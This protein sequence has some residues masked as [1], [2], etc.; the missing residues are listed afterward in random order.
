MASTLNEYITS[1]QSFINHRINTL[2]YYVSSREYQAD[3]I[4]LIIKAIIELPSDIQTKENSFPKD[5][6]EAIRDLSELFHMWEIQKE[7]DI[8]GYIYQGL[9]TKIKKNEKGQ[10]FTPSRIVNHLI[11]QS[12]RYI[13]F[14]QNDI[15]A[16][17]DPACGSGQFLIHCYSTIISA[18]NGHTDSENAPQRVIAQLVGFDSDPIA[19]IIARENLHKIS[20]VERDK[21][22]IHNIDFLK[23]PDLFNQ[24]ITETVKKRFDIILGNPPW[25]SRISKEEK[26]YF[27]YHYQSAATGINTFSLFIE[28]SHDFLRPGGHIS[29][30]IPEAYLNIKSHR[31]SRSL[32]LNQCKIKEIALWGEQFV[33]VFAPC[34]SICLESCNDPQSRQKN[35]INIQNKRGIE[36]NTTL[37]IPQASYHTTPENIF[38]INYS[39]KA[40]N[41]LSHI[42]DSPNCF[43]LKDR[44]KFFL[45]VVTGDNNRFISNCRTSIYN[46]P[47]IVGKDLNQYCI[48]FSGHYIHFNP[49]QLQQVAP[50]HLYNTKGKIL[51]RFI[52]KH[53][54]FAIDYHGYYS[55]NNVNGFIPHDISLSKESLISLLN[56]WALQ[57]YYRNSYF[58]VKVLRG[59]LERLPVKHLTQVDQQKI[60]KL[61]MDIINQ[62]SSSLCSR[63]TIEDIVFHAYNINDRQAYAIQQF[64]HTQPSPQSE[65]LPA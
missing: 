21:I 55:L 54:T 9:Q 48:N 65:L 27:R 39:R 43:Y 37:L 59:N 25:G 33:K 42:E 63:E 58:T 28:R 46:D 12:L 64:I 51:Y 52:S 38:N 47:I 19:C 36:S 40:V 20:G 15:P 45:G 60:D 53:L 50:V 17:L 32:I 62:S 57:Y 24:S 35:I 29:F 56:S 7:G 41:L 44:A 61:S 8:L 30:L 18:I 16:V 26:R 13:G 34:I 23:K 49:Q 2:Q 1:H 3:C 10:Y 6:L 31:D 14:N 4:S 22:N 11:R 5:V